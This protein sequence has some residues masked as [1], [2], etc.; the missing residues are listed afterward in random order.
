[1]RI[2]PPARARNSTVR[3]SQ[4]QS[5]SAHLYCT[6]FNLNT[7]QVSQSQCTVY[8]SPSLTIVCNSHSAR[9]MSQVLSLVVETL[10][11]ELNTDQK[12]PDT[13]LPEW[14]GKVGFKDR[15]SH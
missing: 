7:M 15:Y 12:R 14:I 1:M 5:Y 8:T 6:F 11:N 9:I 3:V 13:D 2:A 10:Y 4:S